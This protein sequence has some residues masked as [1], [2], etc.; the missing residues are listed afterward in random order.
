MKARRH[1]SSAPSA[2]T[3]IELLVVIAIIAILATLLLPALSRAKAQAHSIKCRSNLRQL[4]IQLA[5]YVNDHSAY[6][7]YAYADTICLVIVEGESS[8]FHLETHSLSQKRKESKNARLSKALMCL[9]IW[10][11]RICSSVSSHRMATM[12]TGTLVRRV[13]RSSVDW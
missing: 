4:G 10:G 9:V 12:G 6:P 11:V 5:I 13:R 3:M 8:G 2:F 1:A 7:S